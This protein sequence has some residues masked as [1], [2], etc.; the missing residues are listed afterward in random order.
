MAIIHGGQSD[1]QYA[2]TWVENLGFVLEV[3]LVYV[4]FHL[5]FLII[6]AIL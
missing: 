2:L 3:F 6:A 1:I 4:S 5:M